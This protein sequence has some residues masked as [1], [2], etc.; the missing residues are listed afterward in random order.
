MVGTLE[1]YYE[2]CSQIGRH[3]RCR[4]DSLGSEK[5]LEVKDWSVCV[6]STLQSVTTV[7][8]WLFY[9]YSYGQDYV[10]R[11]LFSIEIESEVLFK[12]LFLSRTQLVISLLPKT[13]QEVHSDLI[14][15]FSSQIEN[16]EL[17]NC[18]QR[19]KQTY[20]HAMRTYGVTSQKRRQFPRKTR[21]TANLSSK[22]YVT[23]K[24]RNI[25][26]LL[27]ITLLFKTR[28]KIKLSKL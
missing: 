2:T 14:F 20:E 8:A 24:L 18:F 27:Q 22:M 19:T 11:S 17:R 13:K 4:H 16:Y 23:M 7:D 12:L 28:K 21:A 6:N 5:K 26:S 1:K 15:S 3:N 25:Q 10:C 9:K